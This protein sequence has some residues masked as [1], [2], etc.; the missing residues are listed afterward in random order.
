MSPIWEVPTALPSCSTTQVIVSWSRARPS[1]HSRSWS[2]E[3]G[4]VT[5][6]QRVTSTS[7]NQATMVAASSV[8]G[9]RSRHP[10]PSM[11][12]PFTLFSP[13]HLGGQPLHQP[14]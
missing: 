2:T 13:L 6:S 4:A 11:I 3:G 7:S 9:G 12:G 10:S 1:I 5:S 14:V 8:R